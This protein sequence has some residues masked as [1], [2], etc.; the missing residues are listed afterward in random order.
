M[1]DKLLASLQFYFSF[2]LFSSLLLTNDLFSIL[3]EEESVVFVFEYLSNGDL[4]T[5]INKLRGTA[6]KT[7][8]RGIGKD[9]TK[10][11]MGQLV[12]AIELLQE[13]QIMHRDLKPMN[14]MLDQN[15]NVKL[16]DFGDAKKINEKIEEDQDFYEELDDLID[17]E[18]AACTDVAEKESGNDSFEFDKEVV[19]EQETEDGKK[20]V[21]KYKNAYVPMI[22]ER[23]DTIVGTANYLSPEV[24]MQHQD[25]FQGQTMAIDIWAMGLI[26]WKMLVGRVAFPGINQYLLFQNI[27]N[28]QINW[29]TE[30]VLPNLMDD[31]AKD[32]VE[33]MLQI[34]P[35][36]RISIQEI[37]KHPYFDNFD[38]EKISQQGYDEAKKLI[39]VKL[40][41]VKR[42]KAEKKE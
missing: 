8:F 3:Q 25:V 18:E 24:I 39:D 28:R 16:I 9:L 12:N 31:T 30:D 7:E 41:E 33:K 29:P 21:K 19:V 11:L 36:Q 15:Y 13:K 4:E 17:S 26:F 2:Y 10:I 22:R 40:D 14:V 20:Q 42:E 5:L 1:S 37:K 6:K 38:F 32:L 23:C 34:D 35:H 27:S